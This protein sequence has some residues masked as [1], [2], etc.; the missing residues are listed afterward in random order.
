MNVIRIWKVTK[1]NVAF[2]IIY[3]NNR[4][5]FSDIPN[6]H[7]AIPEIEGQHFI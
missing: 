6:P 2:I 7:Q 3:N 5:C 1:L 4:F